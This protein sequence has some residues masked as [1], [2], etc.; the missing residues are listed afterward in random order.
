MPPTLQDLVALARKAGEILRQGFGQQHQVTHKGLVDLVTEADHRSEEFLIGEI[1]RLF[2]GD[3]IVT[4]ESGRLPGNS[5]G[6]W[7][8]DPLD[9]TVNYAHGLPFFS[10]SLAYAEDEQVIMAAVCDPLRQE[11]FSA[12]RG[13]GA[14]LNDA[15]I[16]VSHAEELVQSLLATGFAYDTWNNPSNNLENYARF[17]RLSQGVRRFGSAALDGCYLAAGRLDGYWE[18]KLEPWDVAAC[19]LIAE[20]AGATVTGYLGS[21]GYVDPPCSILAANPVLHAK[22]LA[23][24]RRQTM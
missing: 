8:I 12:E 19:G 23:V 3:A 24:L 1:R 2:P 18:M 16:R 5:G 10:V 13:R 20:E 4:E 9:G 22:M 7:Y 17:A 21:P 11:I 15:P 14:W 6:R